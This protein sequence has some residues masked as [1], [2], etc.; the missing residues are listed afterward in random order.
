VLPR[1]K[2]EEVREHVWRNVEA[3]APGGGFVF[4]AVHDVQADVP[5][6]NFIAM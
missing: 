6:E 1:G 2:P 5:P 3:L 4:T